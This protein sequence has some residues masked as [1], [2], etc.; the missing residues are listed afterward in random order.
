MVTDKQ[1]DIIFNWLTIVAIV[2]FTTEVVL[3]SIGKKGYFGEFF[4][5]LDIIATATL[6][7]DITWIYEAIFISEDSVG[8]GDQTSSLRASRASRAGSRA[9][10]VVR[11]IRLIRLIRIMKLYKMHL[12]KQRKK[13]ELKLGELRGPVEDDEPEDSTHESRVGKKL[14]EMTT[15]RVIMIV[16]IMLFISPFWRIDGMLT[17]GVL[18]QSGAPFALD[19]VADAFLRYTD[20]IE[21]NPNS[22]DLPHLK[23]LYEKKMLLLIYYNNPYAKEKTV[24]TAEASQCMSPASMRT[25]LFWVGY[26]LPQ[27]TP[28]VPEQAYVALSPSAGNDYDW[29]T[30][31]DQS[32]G[33]RSGKLPGFVKDR[34]TSPWTYEC[35]EESLPRARLIGVSLQS[36]N[37]CPMALRHQERQYYGSSVSSESKLQ[38]VIYMDQATSV[39]VE[40]IYNVCLTLFVVAVLA[41]GSWMFSRDANTLVLFPVE[42]MILRMKKIGQNPFK[43]M[44]MSED[45]RHKEL[46]DEAKT[47]RICGITI[48]ERWQFLLPEYFKQRGAQDF[49]LQPSKKKVMETVILEKTIVKLG[50]LC[51]LGFGEAGSAIIASNMQGG[52]SAEIVVMVPG[53]RVTAIFGFCDIRNFTDATEILQDDVHGGGANA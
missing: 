11:L 8:E 42:R 44:K 36:N 21:T 3:S 17:N 19:Q 35:P 38:F 26:T 9:G 34:L 50:G 4:F 43:A 53:R 20:R 7:L 41:L 48:S 22:T 32:G 10:R 28:S 51:A 16:L 29:D 49:E 25:T 1:A 14:T 24:C 13:E 6:P 52:Q 47:V 45:E 23:R 5:W 27:S 33:F 37:A 15:R 2:I 12:E 18:H 40:A 46:S 31:Y 30:M 39:S